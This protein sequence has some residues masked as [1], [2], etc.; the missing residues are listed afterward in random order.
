M[1]TSALVCVLCHLEI[2]DD[3]AHVLLPCQARPL[4]HWRCFT[5]ALL[6]EGG[7]GHLHRLRRGP[8]SGGV[9]GTRAAVQSPTQADAVQRGAHGGCVYADE[10]VEHVQN[11]AR[12]RLG[13]DWNVQGGLTRIV[14]GLTTLFDFAAH[15]HGE[16]ATLAQI[17][18]NRKPT[19][20]GGER[21]LV[22]HQSVT[23]PLQAGRRFVLKTHLFDPD[24][25]T[26]T[27][28]GV[29]I[30]GGDFVSLESGRPLNAA[31]IA[32]PTHIALARIEPWIKEQYLHGEAYRVHH[33][34]ETSAF[35]GIPQLASEI[36]Q[37][38]AWELKRSVAVSK[39]D[40]LSFYGAASTGEPLFTKD[41]M[42]DELELVWRGNRPWPRKGIG[43]IKT[44][45]T[46]G[47]LKKIHRDPLGEILA[48]F[49][50]Q[51][52]NVAKAEKSHIFRTERA[53]WKVDDDKLVVKVG[54]SA[55][56]VE[57]ISHPL[58]G[59]PSRTR[60][61]K[62]HAIR[63]AAGSGAAGSQAEA[64]IPPRAPAAQSAGA[65]D[66]LRAFVATGVRTSASRCPAMTTRPTLLNAGS[67]TKRPTSAS[68]S[69]AQGCQARH[70]RTVGAVRT[71]SAPIRYNI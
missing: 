33:V 32:G 23:A 17:A 36:E 60:T 19:Q 62:S 67:P 11:L 48:H 14:N 9:L 15:R 61:S 6:R 4:A 38:R 53:L 54:E 59:A 12:K 29:Q 44:W 64:M 18:T 70:L 47:E 40:I 34:G 46:A 26:L 1:A 51:H 3:A 43:G 27:L 8:R 68:H 21:A 39:A 22:R 65:D 24:K 45:P 52:L 42:C 56:W 41:T 5:T 25:P 69:A 63:D 49:R 30:T 28:R 16:T 58:F 13:G 35:P 66:A 37:L 57:P 2:V 55:A 10:W 71:N 20:T 31:R 7:G 50:N